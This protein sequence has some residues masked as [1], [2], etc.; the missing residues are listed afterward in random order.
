M[1]PRNVRFSL[2][3]EPRK[4]AD[5]E[6]CHYRSMAVSITFPG[7]RRVRS[8]E[9]GLRPSLVARCNKQTPPDLV[10]KF[11]PV[12]IVEVILW[13]V[14]RPRVGYQREIKG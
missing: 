8:A 10:V 1:E 12:D 3:Q 14:L 9:A 11:Q 13:L 6:P 7:H 5:A 4:L 2:T